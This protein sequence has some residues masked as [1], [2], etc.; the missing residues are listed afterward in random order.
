MFW[1]YTDAELLVDM[2]EYIDQSWSGW[3]GE[4]IWKSIEQDLQFQATSDALGHVKLVISICEHEHWSF[5]AS[6]N[7]ECGQ[8]HEISNQIK[9]FFNIS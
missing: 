6:V 5:N 8:L 3:E 1:G 2:F 7:I 9:L 4:L